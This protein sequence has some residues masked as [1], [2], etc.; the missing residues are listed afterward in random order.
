MALLD[1]IIIAIIAL[2]GIAGLFAGLV[3]RMAGLVSLIVAATVAFF[4]ASPVNAMLADTG[5]NEI[6]TNAIENENLAG[7]CALG[8]IWIGCFIILYIV[9]R[10]LFKIFKAIID[11]AKILALVDHTLG[12]FVG[13]ASGLVLAAVVVFVIKAVGDYS[14]DILTWYTEQVNES[15]G[16]ATFVDSFATWALGITKDA[17]EQVMPQ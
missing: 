15:M 16:I 6:F 2:F 1:I 9:C 14:P 4:I 10:I 17:V 12:A 7:M 5:Y 13:L 3:K 8:V 11:K